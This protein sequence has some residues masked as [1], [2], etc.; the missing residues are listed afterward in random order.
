M[1]AYP[2][3]R[4]YCVFLILLAVASP[5]LGTPQ[6]ENWF[7]FQGKHYPIE[8]DPIGT[9][10]AKHP[11]KKPVRLNWNSSLSRGY[12][13]WYELRTDQLFLSDLKIS[14]GPSKWKSVLTETFGNTKGLKID[15]YTGLFLSRYGENKHPGPLEN[16]DFRKSYEN[17]AVFEFQS[18]RLTKALFFDNKGFTQFSAAQFEAYK[19]T[20]DFQVN[21]ERYQSWGDTKEDAELKVADSLFWYL[22]RIL[23]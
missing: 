14:Q 20:Q 23:P 17:Y 5:S 8:H 2:T 9:Y 16:I 10:F 12:V 22:T 11:E 4:F 6:M 1:R 19:K 15:W 18:G 21:V 3:S 7:N 13:S